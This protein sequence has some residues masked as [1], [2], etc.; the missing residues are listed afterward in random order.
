MCVFPEQFLSDGNISFDI[1]VT[2]APVI[3]ANYIE[4]YHKVGKT[5][6]HLPSRILWL[7]EQSWKW[8]LLF[9]NLQ[10]FTRY[11]NTTAAISD[12]GF[13][14]AQ[15]TEHRMLYFWVSGQNPIIA[16]P[17]ERLRYKEGKQVKVLRLFVGWLWRNWIIKT[18][19]WLY[20][21]SCLRTLNKDTKW[22]PKLLK[23]EWKVF[24]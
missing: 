15:L 7:Q 16:F 12:S 18:K 23:Y 10:G 13:R 21:P 14:P 6:S 24:F 17:F 1:G 8:S 3:T 9:S 4:S 20:P 11:N 2:A 22:P 19:S 5:P